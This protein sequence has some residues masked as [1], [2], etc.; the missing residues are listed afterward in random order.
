LKLAKIIPLFKAG[1]QSCVNNYRPIALLSV[2][3]KILE[4]LMYKRLISYIE[5]KNILF[6]NQFGFRSNHS[7]IQAVLS[8]T[9]KI[10]QAIENKKH[11]CGIFL[12]L[13]KAFDTVDHVN[14]LQKL[15]CYGIRGIVKNWFESYL[16]DRKQYVSI[17]NTNSDEELVTCGVPQGSVL[18]PLLF[19][20]YVNDFSNCSKLF[21]FHLFADDS[22]LFCSNDN[23]SNLEHQVNIE[24]CEIYKWLCANKLSSNIDKTNF[25]IFRS[26]QRRVNYVPKLFMNNMLLKQE[27]SIKYLG[28]H[29][30]SHF[31]SKSQIIYISKNIKRSIGILCKLRHYVT[32]PILIQLYY[33]LIYPFLTYGII[34]WG[35]TYMTTLH[36][37]N[38]LQKK[39]TRLMTFSN[40]DEHTE[41]LFKI[42]GLLKLNDL[43][44]LYNSLFMYDFYNNKLPLS[45]ENF[46]FTC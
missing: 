14:L 22:N 5:N 46:F 41:P 20:L 30:D 2:F 43:I 12:D 18:G 8:I 21:D 10:Q 35:N 33:S 42:K 44:F 11:S 34:I 31:N 13:S 25:V 1:C 26:P 38:I 7:T 40:F 28:I 17:G 23:L 27:D 36:P 45:F 3:D 15:E 6:K 39:A 9:D 16:C 32:L 24:L 29:I 19:L 37:L 4:K